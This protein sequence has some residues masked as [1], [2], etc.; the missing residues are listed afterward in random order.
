MTSISSIDPIEYAERIVALW[1]GRARS[2]F[3]LDERLFRQ[4]LSLERAPKACFGAFDQGGALIGAILAKAPREGLASAAPRKGFISFIVVA[5]RQGRRGIGSRLLEAS[6]AWLAERGVEILAFGGDSY[7]FFPGPPIDSSAEAC[8]LDAFLEAKG[9][10]PD[11]GPVEEDLIADLG[12]LDFPALAA[13]APL[14]PGYEFALYE[15]PMRPELERFFGSSFPGRWQ[16]DTFEALEAGMRPADLA[17]L[18]ERGSLSIVGFSRIYDF[19]SPVL[20][21]GLYWR[22]L[23]GPKPGALGPIG[24]AGSVRGKGLGLALLRLCLEEL[25]RRG[26]RKM[27]IDWTS[28]GSFYAKMGFVPWKAYRMYSKNLAAKGSK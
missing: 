13:K 12:E 20:G 5:E 18:L 10:G 11:S 3:P 27:V 28:L 1:N 24:V 19:E 23:L 26:V 4:Q 25:A 6:E 16:S 21:P 8:A 17:L 14:A 2:G 15:E 22:E 9:F 7:H